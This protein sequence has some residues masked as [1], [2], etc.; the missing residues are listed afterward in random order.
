M[1]M[2]STQLSTQEASKC[3]ALAQDHPRSRA[4]PSAE[5]RDAVA[6]LAAALRHVS[7]DEEPRGL[8]DDAGAPR[9]PVSVGRD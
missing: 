3:P 1:R 7:P 9:S 6:A 2:Y 8:F 4:L 5:Q